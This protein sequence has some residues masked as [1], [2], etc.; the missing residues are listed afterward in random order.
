MRIWVFREFNIKKRHRNRWFKMSDDWYQIRSWL[1]RGVNKEGERVNLD[2][3]GSN[4]RMIWVRDI[5]VIV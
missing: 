4:E 5:R 2:W 3:D 1:R